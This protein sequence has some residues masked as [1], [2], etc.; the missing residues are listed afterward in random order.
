[1]GAYL[2]VP[3]REKEIDDCFFSYNPGL[4]SRFPIRFQIDPYSPKQ[5]LM[6]FTK[7]VKDNGW[8]I[9]SKLKS[10]FFKKNYDEFK[11]Y[12]RDMEQ[13]FTASKRAHSRRIFT[14]ETPIKKEITIDDLELGFQIFLLNRP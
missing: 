9:D 4:N 1:M 12:G 10:T 7:I 3:K 8:T 6:I 13:L 2:T 11:A 14:E 5:L